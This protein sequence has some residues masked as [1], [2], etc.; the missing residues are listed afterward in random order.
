MDH[1]AIP[2]GVAYHTPRGGQNVEDQRTSVNVAQDVRSQSALN[3][4]RNNYLVKCHCPTIG[5][6]IGAPGRQRQSRLC[7]AQHRA[8]GRAFAP[9]GGA[10]LSWT[11]PKP[12]ASAVLNPL[13]FA[14]QLVRRGAVAHPADVHIS[15]W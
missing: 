3:L 15:L 10:T 8:R 9:G 6:G 13:R 12:L 7:P 1:S 11:S 14:E 4:D 2:F 5:P